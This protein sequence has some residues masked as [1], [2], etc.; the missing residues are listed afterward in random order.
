MKIHRLRL[1]CPD[2]EKM[3]AFYAGLLGFPEMDRGAGSVAFQCGASNLEFVQ[4]E[5]AYN[6]F[7]HNIPPDFLHLAADW[8]AA[9][10]IALLPFEGN[11]VVPFPNWDAQAI[12]FHDPA[13]NILEFI[14]R[15]RIPQSGK[16]TF[17]N[18]DVI[19]ISEIGF[20]TYAHAE[21]LAQLRG[22]GLPVFGGS[23]AIFSA[24]GDDHGLFIL[25]DAAHKSWIPNM[26]PA[27]PFPFDASVTIAGTTM[28]LHW[29]NVQL[30]AGSVT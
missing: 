13:G 4:G 19:G 5:P 25:V 1:H 22:L 9:R 18:A 20:A 14:A 17:G 21:T 15:N 8:V 27:L 10:G 23:T 16:T 12:Y 30:Q 3:A 26:E 29:D 11:N 2:I 28:Q 7:A 24:L 6:H